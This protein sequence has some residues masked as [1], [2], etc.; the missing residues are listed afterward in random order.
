MYNMVHLVKL[1]L[2]D[3][4]IAGRACFDVLKRAIEMFQA[5]DPESAHA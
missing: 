3:L 4:Y 5:A 2:T 1:N